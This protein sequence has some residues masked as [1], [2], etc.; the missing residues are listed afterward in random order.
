VVLGLAS[1][2]RTIARQR[3]R[4][5]WLR[6]GDANTKLFH[7]VANGRRT[8]NYIAAVRVGEEMATTQE[9]KNEVFTE[10][11]MRLLGGIQNRQFTIN[12]EEIDIPVMD[13]SELDH[14]FT[15]EEVW[16]TIREMPGD[17][18]PGP[19]GFT[20]A[21]YQR[22]WPIIK[23]D[24]LAGLMKLGVGDGGGF[25]RLNRALIT[26][27]PKKPEA[28]ETKD[29]RPISLVHSFAKLFSKIVANRLRTRLGEIVSMNQSAFIKHRSLHDNFVL[30][31][32]VVRKINTRRQTG[33]LLK[34]DIA[35]AF[36]SI[37]WSFL[38]EVLRRMG[39]G[40]RFLKWIALLLYTANTRVMVNGVSGERILHGRGLRQGDPTSPMLFVAAME[41]LSR[42]VIKAVEVELFESLASISPIQRISVY[43]DDVVL[44]LKPEEKELWAVK[45]ILSIFGEASGLHVNFGKTTATMIRGT[46]TEEERTARILGCELAAFPIRYLGLQLALRPLTRAEWQPLLDQVVKSVPAWQRG[47][48][49]REGRLVLINSVVTARA[50]HQ[51]VVAEAP[52][53]L[54]EEINKW[55]RAFFWAGGGEVRGGQCL[56]AWSSICKPRE[57]GGLGV[58]DLKLQ[59]LAL[60]VRW[61][62][63]R[64][65]DQ[66]RPWKGLPGLKDPE[67]EGVFQS[68]AHFVVGDGRLTYF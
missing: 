47:L 41:D 50:V 18:A 16:S 64:R 11:Y 10:E 59:G 45:N 53:W 57:F 32:Q 51:M 62:W 65:T 49:S 63:L 14:M 33:V 4:I 60:R 54:L 8:K 17:R 13:L 3:S 31:R 20:G 29:Y 21:F 25:A 37:S 1:L 2:E 6:E 9:R 39:F 28:I 67:A 46:P 7:A 27:I 38:F 23:E 42:M 61:H 58:K 35:R 52:M 19:D 43:A 40:E 44:F 15:E 26:L 56:V 22:A 34:L 55:M 12:L 66:E 30:V 48:V 5:R 24:I 68:L 36:D